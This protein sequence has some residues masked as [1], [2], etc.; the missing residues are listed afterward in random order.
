VEWNIGVMVVYVHHRCLLTEVLADPSRYV[1]LAENLASER[2]LFI[3]F[4][5]SNVNIQ[6]FSDS[7]GAQPRF[8]RNG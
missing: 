3:L 5:E 6:Q 8:V 7:S 4:G 1:N 2:I